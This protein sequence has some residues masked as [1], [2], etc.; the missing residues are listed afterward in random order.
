MR[1]SD[2][3]IV[4]PTWVFKFAVLVQLALLALLVPSTWRVPIAADW[5]SLVPFLPL[6]AGPLAGWAYFKKWPGKSE[7]AIYP[8]ALLA[9]VLLLTLGWIVGPGQYIMAGLRR[10]LVDTWLLQADQWLGISVPDLVRW[11]QPHP[12]LVFLARL[13]YLTLLGQ[14]FAIVLVLGFLLKDRAALLEYT[15]HFHV[16]SVVTLLCL[17]LWPAHGVYTHPG[18]S[19]LVDLTRFFDHFAAARSG[20]PFVVRFDAVEGLVSIPSFHVAGAWMVTWATR[21]FRLLFATLLV[22]NLCLTAS[23]LLLGVHYAVDLVA[24][25]IMCGTSV[26]L[27]RRV[28][29]TRPPVQPEV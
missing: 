2:E 27:Y 29:S 16:C 26:W 23:T 18:I 24:T 22:L 10:P 25:A 3:Q 12:Q 28:S 9:F 5:Q 19:S 1:A 17:G 14:F 11:I 4:Y 21:R 7:E 13:A 6:G 8:D 15:F 20:N